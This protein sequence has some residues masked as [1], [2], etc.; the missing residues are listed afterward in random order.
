MQSRTVLLVLFIIPASAGH[1]CRISADHEVCRVSL[2]CSEAL[3]RGIKWVRRAQLEFA[4]VSRRRGC[5]DEMTHEI[6][7]AL[8]VGL[9]SGMLGIGL[10][11]KKG[12]DIKSLYRLY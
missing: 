3:P 9:P 7:R 8:F 1:S 2:K 10:T 6:Q 12:K 5:V 4:G 11:R